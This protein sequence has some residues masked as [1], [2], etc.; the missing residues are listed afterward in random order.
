MRPIRMWSKRLA[1]DGVER[2]IRWPGPQGGEELLGCSTPHRQLVSWVEAAGCDHRQD[3]D[4]TVAE[5]CLINVRVERA[6][7]FGDMGQVELDR[8]A[9]T[10]LEVN[11]ERTLLRVEDVPGVRLAVQQLLGG[12]SLANRTGRGRERPR[13]KVPIR[14][15]ER[16]RSLEVPHNLLSFPH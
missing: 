5:Q 1:G 9:T 12:S 16:R 13:Q 7:A 6:D 10:R 3:E 2:R 14:L 11:E 15:A 4:P 8:P